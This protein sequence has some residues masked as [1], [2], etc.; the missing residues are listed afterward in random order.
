M[1]HTILEQKRVFEGKQN[2]IALQTNGTEEK[3][4]TE[5][6]NKRILHVS[7]FFM[8]LDSLESQSMI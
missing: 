4:E 6:I 1:Y 8:F 3:R 2:T 7:C 5:E